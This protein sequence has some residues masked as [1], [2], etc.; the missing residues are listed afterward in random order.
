MTVPAIWALIAEASELITAAAE[1]ASSVV[2]PS[3]EGITGDALALGEVDASSVLSALNTGFQTI[4]NSGNALAQAAETLAGADLTG[5]SAS[6]AQLAEA[7]IASLNSQ[8]ANVAEINANSANALNAVSNQVNAAEAVSNTYLRAAYDLM[9]EASGIA[10]GALSLVDE[11]ESAI[12]EFV[13]NGDPGPLLDIYTE[14]GNLTTQLSNL[15]TG[16]AQTVIL[17]AQ[18]AIAA[19]QSTVSGAMNEIIDIITEYLP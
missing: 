17:L 4:A 19:A 10:Q 5:L 1:T 14:I 8:A 7:Q 6:D 9:S 3:A 11:V 16:A 2:I 12:S 13:A 15:G 18:G